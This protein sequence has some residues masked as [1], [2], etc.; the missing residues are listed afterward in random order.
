MKI[1]GSVSFIFVALLCSCTTNEISFDI[2]KQQVVSCNS[3]TLY[4]LT[5]DDKAGSDIFWLEWEDSSHAPLTINLARIPEGYQ[6]SKGGENVPISNRYITLKGSSSYIITRSGGDAGD[7]EIEII[8]DE[9]GKV[10]KT[11]H[12]DCE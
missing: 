12:P 10:F 4:N 1:I 3:K 6:I 8:T 11:S 5:V 9:K 7:F 2:N